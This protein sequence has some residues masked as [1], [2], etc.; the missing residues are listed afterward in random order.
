MSQA[1]YNSAN[2]LYRSFNTGISFAEFVAR[3]NRTYGENFFE[4]YANGEISYEEVRRIILQK[5]MLAGAGNN[6]P[7]S[8]QIERSEQE[9]KTENKTASNVFKTV[10][11]VG[12]LAYIGY[13]IYKSR[14]G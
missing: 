3:M 2:Q 10:L 1:L 13:R 14:K 6:Q 11:I 8:R 4:K 9:S 12:A 7:P 5:P